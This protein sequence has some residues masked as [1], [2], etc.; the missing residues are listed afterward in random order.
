MN[1]RNLSKQEFDNKL[2][3]HLEGS[4]VPYDSESWELMSQKL[5]QVLP[6]KDSSNSRVFELSL[7]ALL[8]SSL[9]FWSVGTFTQKASSEMALGSTNQPDISEGKEQMI[10]SG[11]PS[12]AKPTPSKDTTLPSIQAKEQLNSS[13]SSSE[14]D[15]ATN[16]RNIG[17]SNE[18]PSQRLEQADAAISATS[19]GNVTEKETAILG[20]N[21]HLAG[22]GPEIIT[23]FKQELPDSIQ[24]NGLEAGTPVIK[25]VGSPWL[26]GIGYAP[27]ISLVGF[28]ET[29]KP[30][31]NL[32]V[33]VE[34][35]FGSRWSLQSGLI[36]SKKHYKA[37]GDDYNAPEGFWYYGTVPDDTD[38]TCDVL[39]IPLN[40]RYYF[41]S[42]RHNRFFAS[43]GFSSYIMLTED[44]YYHYEDNYDPDLVDSWGV[45]NENQHFFG[46]YNFSLGYQK[47]LGSQWFLE[48]EPF[49]KVPLGGVG[50]GEVKLWST[51]SFFSLKYNFR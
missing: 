21:Y 36:Y 1:L 22:H 16:A 13:T 39:D 5:D 34:Y 17:S 28:G 10:S 51:G 48:I 7:V 2:K 47:A 32:G 49:I 8:L 19:V 50:F 35:Q 46:I 25:T 43:T 12:T 37:A 15:S 4:S 6:G 24:R 18:G 31:T 44:Y 45:S 14:V 11:I 26:V 41:N 30:G 3:E 40:L 9:F 23:K 42:S 20:L 27:D 33:L 38:A 29:T